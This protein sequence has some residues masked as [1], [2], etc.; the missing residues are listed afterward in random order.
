VCSEGYQL[1]HSEET[2]ESEFLALLVLVNGSC[3]PVD[4]I[5][6]RVL[7]KIAVY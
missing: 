1:Q 6:L 7:W 5:K 3:H 2:S 4:T